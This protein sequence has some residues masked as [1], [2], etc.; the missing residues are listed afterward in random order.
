MM[1]P[2]SSNLESSQILEAENGFLLADRAKTFDAGFTDSTTFPIP[3]IF[4]CGVRKPSR[5]WRLF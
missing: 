1:Q 4:N 2:N 5:R 3:A